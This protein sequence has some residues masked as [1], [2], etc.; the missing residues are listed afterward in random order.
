MLPHL[1]V[2]TG[3]AEQAPAVHMDPAEQTWPQL[4]Q[5]FGSAAG[6]EQTLP[7]FVK[8]TLQ[9]NVQAPAE[10]MGVPLVTGGHTVPHAPQLFVSFVVLTQAP[11][12]LMKDALQLIPQ[13]P[14]E[15]RGVPFATAGQTTAQVPQLFG[16]VR[17]FAQLVPP[18][19]SVPAAWQMFPHFHW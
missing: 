8:D 19:S 18:Q 10:Q 3:Q 7:H 2:P 9:V 15:Q 6:L 16:S 13:T 14:L 1:V 5:L 17:M 12:Q 4:P 11:P